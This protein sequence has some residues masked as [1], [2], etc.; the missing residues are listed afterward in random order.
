MWLLMPV[1]VSG[2]HWALL[3][4]H[5]PSKTVSIV[6]S[7]SM[8]A[9]SSY[10]DKWRYYT[11]I[12][13]VAL[14]LLLMTNLTL[15]L[16]LCGVSQSSCVA[17]VVAPISTWSMLLINELCCHTMSSSNMLTTILV[18]QH[19]SVDVSQE[20]D[21]ICSCAV[22]NKLTINT[23][24]TKEIVFHRPASRHLNIPPPLPD[25]ERLLNLDIVYIISSLPRLPYTALTVFRKDSI[26]I[27]YLMLNSHNT[28]QFHHSS[29]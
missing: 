23:G 15:H 27:Y 7:L 28:K 1:N 16:T 5:V 12:L 8:S 13:L 26:I 19:S 3:A 24:K 21:N 6:D 20:Y 18:G 14:S 25:I 9:A 22:R 2:I 29:I 17:K 4:A 11:C 10:V